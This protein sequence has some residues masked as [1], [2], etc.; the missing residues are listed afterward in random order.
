MG[1]RSNLYALVHGS[2]LIQF[3][4]IVKEHELDTC[5]VET[6]PMDEESYTRFEA[7]DLKWYDGYSDV[8]AIN[9]IFTKS[10]VSALLRIGEEANDEEMYS[11]MDDAIARFDITYH[12][13]V[14]F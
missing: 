5:F 7:N 11:D 8:S 3:M 14:D 12:H 4:A 13:S 10:K 2:D 6:K 1:Y 9:A